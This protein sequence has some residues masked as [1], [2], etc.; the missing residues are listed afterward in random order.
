MIVFLFQFYLLLIFVGIC[1][2][3]VYRLSH[4]PVKEEAGIW[5]W[6]DCF[7]QSSSFVFIGLSLRLSN[8]T[9]SILTLSKITSLTGISL[10]F[11]CL[12]N[13]CMYIFIMLT[14]LL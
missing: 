5:A 10:Y 3:F 7:S 12:A 1:M 14:S 11:T 8:G 9:P 4:I 2:I 13:M 6:M